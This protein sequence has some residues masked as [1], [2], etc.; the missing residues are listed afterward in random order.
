[1]KTLWALVGL[2]IVSVLV[3][4]YL[5]DGLPISLP[6]FTATP[7]VPAVE[8]SS[9]PTITTDFD[10]EP[11]GGEDTD[12]GM[13][14][15]IAIESQVIQDDVSFVQDSGTGSVLESGIERL[16]ALLFPRLARAT[17]TVLSYRAASSCAVSRSPGVLTMSLSDTAYRVFRI[18][19]GTRVTDARIGVGA[20]VTLG[21]DYSTCS[22]NV[23]TANIVTRSQRGGNGS[24]LAGQS[25]SGDCP[26]CGG[27]ESS[28]GY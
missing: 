11:F 6:V 13:D 15:V 5:K 25:S 7:S 23:C 22:D 24:T 14:E 4:W 12:K 1:M 28:S 17:G 20:V 10:S 9:L 19:C 26:L 27:G 2:G 3:G 18:P 8:N 21:Y 16:R